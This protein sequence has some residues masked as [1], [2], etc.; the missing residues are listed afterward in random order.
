[1]HAQLPDAYRPPRGTEG[2][3]PRSAAD[4][5]KLI[6]APPGLKVELVAAEPLIQSPV[7]VD[8]DAAGRLWVCEMYDYPSGVDGNW[9]PGGTGKLLQD[10]NGDGQFDHASA[11]LDGIPFPT[12]L[13]AYGRGLFVCAAPDLLYAEDTNGDGKADQ[14]EKI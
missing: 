12:G 6:Q 5:L 10:R 14:V 4:S 13:T 1:V 9:L 8:W 11:F 2:I 7:A 3:A